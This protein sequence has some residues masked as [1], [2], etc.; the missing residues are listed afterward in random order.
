M[1]LCKL[2][3]ISVITPSFKTEKYIEATLTSVL[4]QNYPNL[5]YIVLDGAGDNTR[6]IL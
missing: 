3:K 1:A 4:G 6:H 5:E 2:P